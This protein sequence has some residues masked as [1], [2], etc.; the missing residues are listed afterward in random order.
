M[1]SQVSAVWRN[2]ASPRNGRSERTGMMSGSKGAMRG[3]LVAS[4]RTMR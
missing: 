4:G 1:A 2:R 3:G